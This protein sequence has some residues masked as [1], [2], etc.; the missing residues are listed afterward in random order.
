MDS[1]DGDGDSI[2]RFV[3]TFRSDSRPNI[4]FMTGGEPL[5]KP[6]LVSDIA[7]HGSAIGATS[8]VISGMY[9]ARSKSVPKSVW[10][11][12]LSVDHL[13]ASID[14]FHEAEVSRLAVFDTLGQ[15]LDAGQDISLQVAGTGPDDPYLADLTTHARDF[16]D[17]RV[18]MFVVGL[19]PVG[20]AAGWMTTSICEDVEIAPTPCDVAS[21]PVLSFDGTIVACCNQAVLD[22]PSGYRHLV[23]GQAGKDSWPL[24]AERLASRRLLRSI[25]VVGPEVTLKSVFGGSCSGYCGSCSSLSEFADETPELAVWTDG[26]FFSILEQEVQDFYRQSGRTGFITRHAVPG[27]AHLA[28]LGFVD[29]NNRESVV[30]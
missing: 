2:L 21:W 28:E 22:N 6:K 8:V 7:N 4:V 30:V 12:L 25:R 27:F 13:V 11:A 26:E 9:F 16:F 19:S 1:L 15:L 14:I 17:D 23:V 24:V 29:E 10:D 20:R 3:R 18:P 5:V